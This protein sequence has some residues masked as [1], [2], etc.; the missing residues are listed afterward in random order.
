MI[1]IIEF[2][3]KYAGILKQ[4]IF[5]WLDKYGLTEELDLDVLNNPKELILDAAAIFT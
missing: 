3:E 2:E 1:E 4:L 5:E